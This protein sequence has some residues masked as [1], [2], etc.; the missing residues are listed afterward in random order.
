MALS[1]LSMIYML[2][3]WCLLAIPTCLDEQQFISCFCYLKYHADL[4]VGPPWTAWQSHTGVCSKLAECKP[5][6]VWKLN[7]FRSEWTQLATAGAEPAGCSLMNGT[8]ETFHIPNLL[9]VQNHSDG[10]LSETAWKKHTKEQT[11]D[12]WQVLYLF[13]L[14]S[15]LS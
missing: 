1:C 4:R 15:V 14:R 10:L 11:K 2:L 12:S 5:V 13:Q 7:N 3:G 8:K 9:F 6:Q